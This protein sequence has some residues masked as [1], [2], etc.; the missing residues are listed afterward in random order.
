[1]YILFQ[2]GVELR[3]PPPWATEWVRTSKGLN[4]FK[5]FFLYAKCVSSYRPVSLT[6]NPTIPYSSKDKLLQGVPYS[7]ARSA[8]A[9]TA[10]RAGIIG[11]PVASV[12]L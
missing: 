11:H 4:H 3:L 8:Q 7:F 2:A 5:R 12:A 10:D 1:M 6:P 9:I